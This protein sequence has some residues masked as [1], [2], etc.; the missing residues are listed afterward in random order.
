MRF[1]G[2]NKKL[3][4]T[5]LRNILIFSGFCITVFTVI[6]IWI[7]ILQQRIVHSSDEARTVMVPKLLEQIRAVRNLELL[8]HYGSLAAKTTNSEIRK[9]AAFLAAYAAANPGNQTDKQTQLLVVT[10][11][12]KIQAIAFNEHDPTDWVVMENKLSTRADEL[13][14]LTG[15]LISLKAEDIGSASTSV[16]NLAA[17]LAVLFVSAIAI[18]AFLG[19]RLITELKNK[20]QF[21]N[22]A[23]HD[24]RQRLHGMQLLINTSLRT[25]DLAKLPIVSRIKSC[26][27]DLQRY[28]NNFLEI[29]KIETIRT[30]PLHEKI[31]LQSIF[32]RL[33]VQFEE[34]AI[35]NKIEM[36]FR[37]TDVSILSDET[38]LL[39]ILE[40]LL[41][42]ALKFSRNKVLIAARKRA[43]KVEILVVDNGLGMPDFVVNGHHLPFGKSISTKTIDS[44]NHYGFG[45]GMSIVMRAA[46]LLNTPIGIHTKEGHGSLVKITFNT[47]PINPDKRSIWVLHRFVLQHSF[48]RYIRK[49]ATHSDES[50]RSN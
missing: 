18:M 17:I 22:E 25:P 50:I 42:N 19:W 46:K 48:I 15:K 44:S 37:H 12:N 45:L 10:A 32:Q 23:S 30:K 16:R 21:F 43:G 26:T 14:V 4:L 24:F 7:V 27:T 31:G 8:S 1:K 5:S 6:S 40:N 41:A 28:L 20:N 3:Q 49:K 29:A 36:K 34:V 33:E 38:L 39:K 2:K 47:A 9:D 13:A 35:S 11:Y